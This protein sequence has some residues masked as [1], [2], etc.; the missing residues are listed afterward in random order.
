MADFWSLQLKET[1]KASRARWAVWLLHQ[2]QGWKLGPR[3]ALGQRRQAGLEALLQDKNLAAW[4]AGAFS[5]GRTRWRDAGMSATALGCRRLYAFPNLSAHAILLVGTDELERGAESFLRILALRPPGENVES[6]LD[7]PSLP[8]EEEPVVDLGGSLNTEKALGNVLH[9]LALKIASDAAYLSV[10]SGDSFRVQAGRDC[11]AG[12]QGC[13]VS[14]QSEDTLAQ[15]VSTRQGVIIPDLHQ[16][17]AFSLK[18]LFSPVFAA[19]MGIPIVLGQRVIGQ[20]AFLSKKVNAFGPADLRQAAL[21]VGRLAYAVENAIVF[22]EA[23]HYL[24][25]L[26]MLNE[27]ASA[28]SLGLDVVEASRRVIQHLSRTFGTDRVLVCLLSP[29]GKTLRGYGYHPQPNLPWTIPVETSLVGYVVETGQPAR[30]GDVRQ[31]PRYWGI[32]PAVHS[33]LA[34]PLKYRGK[35]IGALALESTE[36]NAFSPQDEQLMVVI[37][38]HLAGLIENVRLND[39]TRERAARLQ[40][41]VRQLQAARE[42]ALEIASDLDLDTLFQRVIHRA[43]E[44][45]E[46]RGAE[47]GLMDEKEGVIR[48]VVTET[49][50]FDNRGLVIPHMAGVAGRVAAF[51][52]PF[53]VSDYNSWNGRLFPDQISPFKSAAGVPLKYTDQATGKVHVIGTIT[54]MDDRAGKVFEND[55]IELLQLLAPQVAVSIRNARLYQEV[56]ERIEA[57]RLAESRLLRSARLAAVGEM[58]AGVAH[59]LNNPL[60]TVTGFV[61][62]VLADLPPE[63]AAREDLELVLRE[64][65]RA[66]GVVRRLLDFARPA[67]NVRTRTGLNELVSDVLALVSHQAR[68][69]NIE[70]SLYLADNLPWITVDPN[71]IKQVLLNLIS[72]AMSSMPRGGQLTIETACEHREERDW[73]TLA[74]RDTGVGVPRENFERIFEPFFTTRQSGGGTGLGLA[75]SYNIITD[76]G[77]FM[78]LQSEVGKGSSFTVYLPCDFNT[79]DVDALTEEEQLHE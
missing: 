3:H 56:Q 42:T 4:L 57:Q 39:E 34:V 11:P 62:L 67:D 49:P 22:S 59:E 14:V 12:L 21:H 38:S 27:L 46:A 24:Q 75:I 63:A 15:M 6:A 10:R 25:R 76:H 36:P 5:S 7:V 69:Y 8:E 41:S 2:E 19:W 32:D 20:V 51:G 47:L 50:W 73:L 68:T 64:A 61:E 65:L 26:A 28:A 13:D 9:L 44:L 37:A 31:A 54:V 30:L 70:I 78:E 52:E 48:V 33:E 77:G 40:D 79:P 35:V 74:V 60:T 43:R 45:V 58:A 1:C 16:E 71:Q 23:A 17:T 72:N 53:V 18:P 55:A 66:R 29:D